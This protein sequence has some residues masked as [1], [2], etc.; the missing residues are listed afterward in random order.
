MARPNKH[1]LEYFP[2]DIDF[3]E[4]DKIELISGEFGCKGEVI[5][6]RLLCKIYKNGYYYKMTEDESLLLARR[7]GD[8]ISG[9][10]VMEVVKG[11]I[12]RSF[13]DEGVF[14]RFQILTSAGIQR[15][16]FEACGRRSIVKIVEEILLIEVPETITKVFVTETGVNDAESTQSKEKGNRKKIET[17]SKETPCGE[18]EVI[19]LVYPFDSKSFVEAWER[20]KLYKKQQWKFTYKSQVSEQAAL[21]ELKKISHGDEKKALAIIEYAIAKTWKGL[22]E[23]KIN[24]H[25]YGETIKHGH[26]RTDTDTSKPGTILSAV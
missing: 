3:F 7:M 23:L 15:R 19:R 18:V 5:T 26:K 11:L 6:I 17:E 9:S 4:D 22:F 2:F 1:G 8:N 20:W 21:N 13:F 16:F 25:G 14:N 24:H 10:L 12:R